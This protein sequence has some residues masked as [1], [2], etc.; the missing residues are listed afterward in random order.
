MLA[1]AMLQA[2]S[3]SSNTI[4][5]SSGFLFLFLRERSEQE[6]TV[7]HRTASQGIGKDSRILA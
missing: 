5:L 7:S 1:P 4:I 3:T 2:I 6:H